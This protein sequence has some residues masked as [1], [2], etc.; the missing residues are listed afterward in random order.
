MK[1]FI[2]MNIYL[3]FFNILSYFSS[4]NKKT[5][6][7]F[8]YI[9]KS[10]MKLIIFLQVIIDNRRRQALMEANKTGRNWKRLTSHSEDSTGILRFSRTER[11]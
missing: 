3:N 10:H 7:A 6:K 9:T 11:I 2:K 1:I 8:L 5:L 4:H